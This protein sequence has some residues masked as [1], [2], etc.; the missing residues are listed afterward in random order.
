M[1]ICGEDKDREREREI[2]QGK[3]Q[4]NKDRQRD[5]ET[6]RET[7]DGIE[8]ERHVRGHTPMTAY[9]YVYTSIFIA[10]QPIHVPLTFDGMF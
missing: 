8:R 3:K 9:A 4:T 1:Y 7:E 10:T 6:E 2:G 5:R